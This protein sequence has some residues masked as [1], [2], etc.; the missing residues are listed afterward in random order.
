MP[1]TAVMITQP[2][3]AVRRAGRPA[4]DQVMA[5]YDLTAS[6]ASWGSFTTIILITEM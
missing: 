6:E 4:T 5:G 2:T 1:P 3:R